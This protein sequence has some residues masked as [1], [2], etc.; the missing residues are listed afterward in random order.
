MNDVV[1]ITAQDDVDR[2]VAQWAV[3]RPELE[4]GAMAVFGRIYR[5]ARNVGDRQELVYGRYGINRGEFDLLAT[6]RRSGQPYRLTPTA[7]CES[8]ML[9][10]GGMTGRIDRLERRG[11]VKR[12]Q[13]PSD[14]RA[15]VITLTDDGYALV[16]EAVGAGLAA[17]REVLDRLP[18]R[19]RTQLANLL[20]DL[21][22]ASV[23]SAA[24]G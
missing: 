21:L 5:I 18:A 6:L 1:R 20:R 19:S 10:S 16:E 15:L 3:E 2:I 4:T 22:A 17:Q 13:H 24:D 9:T 14:R 7:L 12:S 8:M 23:D 11:L